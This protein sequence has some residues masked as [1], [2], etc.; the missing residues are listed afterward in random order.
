MT[1]RTRFAPARVNSPT[2]AFALAVA[3]A[4][5]CLALATTTRAAG[6]DGWS[7]AT[8]GGV[9]PDTVLTPVTGI[10]VTRGEG[11]L[12]VEVPQGNGVFWGPMTGDVGS[13]LLAGANLLS[14][15]LTLTN[16]ELNGG[17]Y[18]GGTDDS[19]N[20]F[21]QSNELA[22]VVATDAAGN[23]IQRNFVAGGATDSLNPT[24]VGQWSGIDGTRTITWNLDNFTAG[25]MSIAQYMAANEATEARIWFPTQGGDSNGN[26]GPMRFYFDNV[27]L[28]G[29]NNLDVIIGDFEPANEPW[30][31][32]DVN[33]DGRVDVADLGILASNFNDQPPSPPGKAGAD[34][35]ND[36]V[37]N[38]SDLGILSTYFNEPRA[39]GLSFERALAAHPQLNAAVPE[40]ASLVVL[41][42][43][44]LGL[45]V[46][47][48]T[49]G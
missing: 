23:F 34:L 21:A 31:V 38:V 17:A 16:I 39:A 20:G 33:D 28:K 5:S 14:F 40:P 15:D 47:R 35:N 49:R 4:T 1:P 25:G 13:A 3:A 45:L 12:R 22:V 41:G 9:E 8:D 10:G 11:S 44:A 29:P 32:A 36:G 46:R 18:G 6:L 30:R 26:V 48:R 43:G 42:A 27:H 37:V 2:K 24:R 7:D 19:F